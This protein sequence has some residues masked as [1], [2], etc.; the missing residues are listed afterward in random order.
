MGPSRDRCQAGKYSKCLQLARH[1][2][3]HQRWGAE[4]DGPNP[5]PRA[6]AASAVG[7]DITKPDKQAAAEAV[8]VLEVNKTEPRARGYCF[9]PRCQEASSN[10][11][12]KGHLTADGVRGEGMGKWR[13]RPL[14]NRVPCK[15]RGEPSLSDR[16]PLSPSA[17]PRGR[18]DPC[19]V[20]PPAFHAPGEDEGAQR[21]KATCPGHSL[22]EYQPG[23]SPARPAPWFHLLSPDA[24]SGAISH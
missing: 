1:C 2:S 3:G 21:H 10:P 12:S 22:A 9:K 11:T 6:G 4:G 7:G 16:P 14:R 13:G 15:E 23:R 5:P 18:Q 8:V 17:G 24:V 19:L 20:L